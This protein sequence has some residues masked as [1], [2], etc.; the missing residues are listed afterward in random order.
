MQFYYSVKKTGESIN[1]LK[2]ILALFFA[3]HFP[4]A[5]GLSSGVHLLIYGSAI[6]EVG[7]QYFAE[8]LDLKVRFWK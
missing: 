2:L 4:E 3:S 5:L 7:L 8:I 1:L 6:Q